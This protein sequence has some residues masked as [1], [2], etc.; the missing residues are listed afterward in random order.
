MEEAPRLFLPYQR[1]WLQDGARVKIAEKSRRIGWTYAQSWEDVRDQAE[2]LYPAV[3]FSSADESAAREYILYCAQ[4]AKALN[5]VARDLGQVVIDDERQVKAFSIEFSNGAR[6]N[7]LSSNPKAFRS[8]GGKVVLD[9]YGWHDDA[10]GMWAAARP[11][12]TWGFPLRI[13]SS[14]NGIKSLFNRFVIRTRKGELPWSLH[15]VDIYKAVE[16]GLVDKILRR[17][18]TR[19]ERDKWIAEERASVG[20]ESVWLQEYCCIPQ[21]ESTA[22]IPYDMYDS[23]AVDAGAAQAA[24]SLQAASGDLYLGFDIARKKHF[25][26]IWVLERSADILHTRSITVMLKETFRAQRR[27]LWPL[28]AH[29]RLRRAC[30]DASGLGAELAEDAVR[31]F[32]R[33][34]VEPVTFSGPVKEDLAWRLHRR[35]EDQRITVPRDDVAR[36]SFHSVRKTVTAAGNV[37]FEAA[38][39]DET[40]HAD[41]FWA[42]A[43]AVHAADGGE[44]LTPPQIHDSIRGEAR[45]M[46]AGYYD[47]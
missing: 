46:L 36:E 34:R 27:A 20:D 6:I 41:H 1:R 22:F 19:E 30:I 44:P 31:D 5:V 8:K 3:W 10:R 42:A 18:T 13:V 29:P 40:G 43:L 39:S 23:C 17:P 25:S 15:T 28:L 16:E 45:E 2:G 4:W 32:G 14:H 35:M 38:E 26:V 11:T 9:E 21:D 24:D 37:R 47:Q 7:A 33:F 12:I